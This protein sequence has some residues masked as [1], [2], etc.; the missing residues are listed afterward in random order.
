MNLFDILWI[1]TNE[2]G[3]DVYLVFL[4]YAYYIETYA[5]LWASILKK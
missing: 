1:T 4:R 3:N 5:K 2:A